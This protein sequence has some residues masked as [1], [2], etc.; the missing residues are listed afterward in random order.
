[1]S[2]DKML[3]YRCPVLT[4]LN[5]SPDVPY[6]IMFTGIQSL[7][8]LYQANQRLGNDKEA[9]RLSGLVE[10]GEIIL[11]FMRI[12]RSSLETLNNLT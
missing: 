1:M 7:R 8:V 3:P 9:F 4:A 5:I 2:I 6:E 10:Q 12:N 11:S